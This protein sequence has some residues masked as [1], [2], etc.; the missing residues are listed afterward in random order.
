MAAETA[1]GY[2]DYFG[3]GPM[4]LLAPTKAY[5]IQG[6]GPKLEWTLLTFWTATA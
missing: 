1:G 3:R 4:T 5:V 6:D 2:T